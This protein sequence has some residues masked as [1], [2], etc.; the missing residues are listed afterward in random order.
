MAAQSPLTWSIKQPV[1]GP[2]GELGSWQKGGNG[3]DPGGITPITR[4]PRLNKTTATECFG[5]TNGLAQ[6]CWVVDGDG[7]GDGEGDGACVSRTSE[8]GNTAL[9]R[10]P[11]KPKASA[12]CWLTDNM[13]AF[14]SSPTSL[15]WR[16]S[17]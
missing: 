13:S 2:I 11:A 3:L 9:I 5:F 8:A 16:G 15:G 17:K 6:I 1:H 12:Y 10:P 4:P 7:D 14:L